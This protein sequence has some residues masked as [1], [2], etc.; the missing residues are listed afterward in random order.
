MEDC[1]L[2]NWIHDR[3]IIANRS[4]ACDSLFAESEIFLSPIRKIE[5][6]L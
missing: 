3:R 5:T 6:S 1:L 2:N 4:M